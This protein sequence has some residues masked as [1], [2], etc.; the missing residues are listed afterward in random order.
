MQIVSKFFGDL[1]IVEEDIYTFENGMPGFEEHKK[2]VLIPLDADLPLAV[3]QA[4]DNAE[5]GFVVA[6][7]F[8]FKE[9]YGFDLSEE[10]KEDLQIEDEEAVVPYAIVTLKEPFDQSTMNLLAP[11]IINTAKKRGKQIVLQDNKK[12]PL[13]YELSTEGSGK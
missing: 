3:L 2:F 10:D 13:R 6:Y 7:P 4:V 8:A 9:D 11:V 12:Y 1:T 5:I